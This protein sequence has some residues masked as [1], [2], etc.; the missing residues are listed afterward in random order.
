MGGGRRAPAPW[1]AAL[2]AWYAEHR[3]PL[4]IRATRDAYPILV[5]EVM[6]HQTQIGRVGAA[7][8]AFLARFPSVAVLARASTAD[9]IR[10][11]G[12]LGYP[13]RAL[14]LRDAARL[15]VERHDGEV[16]R[17]VAELEALPGIGPYTARAVAATAY[18]VPVT[19]L[20][21]NARRV[22][23]RVLDGRALPAG[24][25]PVDRARADALAPPDRAADWN[26][27]LMDLGASVCRPA[28]DCPACP[29]RS[30][31]AFAAG[32]VPATP[33]APP[34]RHAPAFQDTDRYVR[35]RVLAVLREAPP[36]AWIVIHPEALALPAERVTRAAQGLADD[37]LIELREG[38]RPWLQARLPST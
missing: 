26:H 31:C 27:A 25:G 19:A 24:V 7:L 11:W 32:R 4:A 37:G 5:G 36:D 10:A 2:L 15:M 13:R 28:P 29:V 30:A 18:G 22:I 9:V 38:P 33:D 8:P 17:S 16:P 21:V 1:V 6:S 14:A 20:D 3:R 12:G 23:G 34:R 35:G